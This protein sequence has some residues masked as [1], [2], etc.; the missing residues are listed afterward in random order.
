MAVRLVVMDHRRRGP[1]GHVADSPDCGQRARFRRRR[2]G[3]LVDGDV[4]S[5]HVNTFPD[6]RKPGRRQSAK[7]PPTICAFIC[8]LR[9]RGLGHGLSMA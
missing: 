6:E 5:G 8:F 7:P 3:T 1:A 2:F 9:L 4:G